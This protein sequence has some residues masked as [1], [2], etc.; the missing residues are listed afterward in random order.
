MI[1]TRS[2]I[3]IIIIIV[4]FEKEMAKLLFGLIRKWDY[5]PVLAYPLIDRLRLK[6]T[7]DLQTQL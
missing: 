5:K 6:C 4:S 7:I 2:L 1:I 3:G